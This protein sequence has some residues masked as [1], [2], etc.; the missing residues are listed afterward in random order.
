M[1][2]EKLIEFL[3]EQNLGF[4][5]TIKNNI[6]KFTKEQLKD[7]FFALHL[8]IANYINNPIILKHFYNDVIE[9]LKIT[10]EDKEE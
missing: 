3:Q 8:Q 1:E 2:N 4:R 5:S 7:I 10:W 6:E 9:E